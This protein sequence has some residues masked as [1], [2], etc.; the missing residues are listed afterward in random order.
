MS[1]DKNIC[2]IIAHFTGKCDEND[3]LTFKSFTN[4]LFSKTWSFLN[5]VCGIRLLSNW[6][7]DKSFL[8]INRRV[9]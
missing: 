3:I 6:W 9:K 5:Q 1:V 2:I 4:S 8:S 7:F